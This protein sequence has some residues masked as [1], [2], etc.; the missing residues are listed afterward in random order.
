LAEISEI[1]IFYINLDRAINRKAH[2]ES[3]LQKFGVVGQRIPATD[4][5]GIEAKNVP[6]LGQHLHSNCRWEI[7]NF[8]IAVFESHRKAW[9]AVSETDYPFSII[10]EDDVIFGDEFAEF[11]GSLEDAVEYFDILRLNTFAQT[12][13]LGDVPPLN[14]TI[15]VK[16]ILQATADAGAYVL[17]KASSKRLLEDSK[18][19]CDHVDDFIFNPDRNLRTF[20]LVDPICGQL[21]HETSGTTEVEKLGI[22]ISGRNSIG[23]ENDK[24]AKGPIWFRIRKEIQRA[25]TKTKL[26]RLIQKD[27]ASQI[28]GILKIRMKA[29]PDE[30]GK[31]K[32]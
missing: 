7:N 20:Q 17:T 9:N 19:Y 22:S 23:R 27:Q 30:R 16:S 2:I 6:N 13:V 10:L 29:N 12:R 4:A 11:L 28:P 18:A 1:P 3:S 24:P 25:V 26:R 32:L 8:S 21:I 14:G 5:I 15:E 31:R